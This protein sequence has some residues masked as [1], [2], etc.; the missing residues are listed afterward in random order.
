MAI[1]V[2]KALYQAPQGVP[3]MDDGSVIEVEIEN[4]D[5]VRI[6]GE[7]IMPEEPLDFYRDLSEEIPEGVLQSLAS[8]TLVSIQEDINARSDWEKM[9]S[10]GINLLGLKY[11]VRNEP[12]Q[13]ACGV[14]HPMITEAVVRFQSDT[15][16]E[17][18]PSSGPVQTKIIGKVTEEKERAAERVKDDLNWHLM[19]QMPEFRPE[20]ERMLWNLP[21]GG[22][23]FKKVYR[24]P[25]LGRP[26]SVFVPAEDIIL[27]Y[28]TSELL[29]CERIA[30]RMRKTKLDVER[31]QE[32]GFWRDIE[33]GD[34]P[35][36]A[37]NDIQQKK[38]KETGVSSIN[39]N[40]YTFYEVAMD[41]DFHDLKERTVL[42]EG[43]QWPED[44]DM[45]EEGE[46][47][48]PYILTVLEGTNTVVALR[49]NWRKEDPN[50]LRRLHFVQYNYV[51]GF[52]AYGFGLFHLLGG[53]AQSATSIIRQLVDA[54]TLSNL[55]G[56]L[57]TKGLRI[58]GDDAPISPGEFRDVDVGS[59][60]IKDNIMPLPYKDPSAT[61]YQLFNTI[62]E[63]ARRFA[64]TNDLEISDTSA[65]APVGTTLA[66][67]E[68][69]L[70]T[71]TAVQA[72]VHYSFKQELRLL[73]DLIK[74][75]VEQGGT[76]YPYEVDAPD[77][78]KAKLAD[79]SYVSIIPVSDPN[80]ATMSQ[81]VVQFQAVIQMAEKAPH[82]YD[83]P[84]LHR[85]MLH[86]LGIKNVGK[87]V[88]TEDDIK[89][90]DPVQENQNILMGKPVKAWHWQDHE[91]HIKV[92]M[93]A[94]QDPLIQQLVGQNPK[95]QMIM[96]AMT[97]HIA[98][99][100]GFAYRNKMQMA[101]QNP[102]PVLGKD[103]NLNPE[104]EVQLSRMLAMAAPQIL[105]Q[106][107]QIVAQQQAQK[108]AQDPVLVAQK[109]EQETARMEV[110]RKKWRDQ[111]EMA[112]QQQKVQIEAQSKGVDPQ[113]VMAEMQ[114]KAQK[115]QQDM[116]LQQQKAASELQ[117]N[118][119]KAQQEMAIKAGKARQDAQVKQIEAQSAAQRAAMDA[120]S[121]RQ[122]MMQNAESHKQDARLKQ[123]QAESKIAAQKKAAAAKAKKKPSGDSK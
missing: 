41:I 3:A 122:Q 39:D 96:G 77:G 97:A 47:A 66:L 56:G 11:E 52:G 40:R 55:P 17:T 116:A 29:T 95:A 44:M 72:R 80:A 28:G 53:Y 85:Q 69:Q 58:K 89:I 23:A 111:Q 59:G 74:E 24:C 37:P 15:I 114:M 118:R 5:D 117:I 113:Q 27:P 14:F 100:V 75:D 70:R 93:A 16:M 81:R 6:N 88:P 21:G 30:H 20:H 18:F 61:L 115:A 64:A 8:D 107:Q 43:T 54:G 13:G 67:L 79:Y 82:I 48:K 94:M 42:P 119:E 60:T 31:M 65:Q 35:K 110:E 98:E 76:G 12:W 38:D 84:E 7:S 34:P 57:K 92:H 32:S 105:Q 102:L 99:H 86:V 78:S 22:S 33:I 9:L 103:D 112:I 26:T 63:E 4:P 45:S 51:P 71:M 123:A 2:D 104:I 106:S 91:S 87:L 49:R 121:Q 68:R 73:A 36:L 46:G 101:I 50:K 62:V 90:V 25:T 10:E 108:N 83:Q 19:E 1:N 120:A 109:M